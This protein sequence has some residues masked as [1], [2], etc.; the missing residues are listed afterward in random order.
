MLLRI[1]SLACVLPIV[2]WLTTG[3]PAQEDDVWKDQRVM[4][5]HPSVELKTGRNVVGHARLGE[6]LEVSKVSGDWLWI[7]SRRGWINRSQVVLSDRAIEYFTQRID[8]SASSE[9]HHQRGIALV[10]LGQFEK[11]VMDFDEAIRQDS[12]NLAAYNDR[13]NALSKIGKFD[14]A[15]SD[16]STLIARKVRHPAVHMNRG[17]ALHNKGE[18]DEALADFSAAIRLDGKFAPAWDAGGATR[19][20]KGNYAKAIENFSHAIEHAPNFDR[21][22]NNLA[23]L[24][25]TCP[26]ESRRNGSKAI[27]HATKACELTKFKNSGYL[28]TLAAAYAEAGQFEEAVRRVTEALALASKSNKKRVEERLTLYKAGKPYRQK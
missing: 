20:A 13:G 2:G 22:H 26:E 25:A 27:E 7:E 9:T 15:I 28:D 4:V 10:A 1:L 17:L 5:V 18:Y 23:W 14:R 19:Q 21:A 3:L 8:R 6:L 16:F 24:L 11:A 12:R